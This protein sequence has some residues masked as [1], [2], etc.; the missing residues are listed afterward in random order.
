MIILAIIFV[1]AVYFYL[2]KQ[3]KKV[4]NW[5]KETILITGGRIDSFSNES[6]LPSCI[7]AQGIGKC[8]V[9]LCRLRGCENIIIVDVIAPNEKCPPSMISI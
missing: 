1:I 6:S 2:S 9:E 4:L 7:G 8:I 3:P 5:S